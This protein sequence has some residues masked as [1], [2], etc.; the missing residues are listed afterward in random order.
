VRPKTAETALA[1]LPK[2]ADGSSVAVSTSKQR[3]VNEEFSKK[4]DLWDGN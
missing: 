2:A 4:T 1:T 3:L